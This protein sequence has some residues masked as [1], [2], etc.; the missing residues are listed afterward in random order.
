MINNIRIWRGKFGHRDWE[1][2]A[3]RWWRGRLECCSRR[4]MNPKDCWSTTRIQKE[5]RKGY[6]LQ[7][8]K[9]AGPADT[10]LSNFLPP[11]LCVNIWCCSSYSFVVLCNDSPRVQYLRPKVLGLCKHLSDLAPAP[12]LLLVSPVCL[13]R[14][15]ATSPSYCLY[16]FP[17]HSL[18]CSHLTLGVSHFIFALWQSC[19]FPLG[20]LC[21]SVESVS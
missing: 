20:P 16:Q 13:Q 3:L 4:P 1:K 9:G 10:L 2:D 17:H 5:A 19:C 21:T 14:T 6:S 15:L 11:E 8:L 18:R 12:T 7:V